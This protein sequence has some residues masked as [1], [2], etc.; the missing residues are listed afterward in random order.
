MKISL[1]AKTV[2]GYIQPLFMLEVLERSGIK[3]TQLNI[4]KA[5]YSQPF[6]QHQT[7]W[8]ES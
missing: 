1:D 5:I 3:G 2:F 7:K 4:I 6:S 8:R